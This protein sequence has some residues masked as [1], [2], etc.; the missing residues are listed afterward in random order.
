MIKDLDNNKTYDEMILMKNKYINSKNIKTWN[1]GSNTWVRKKHKN[2]IIEPHELLGSLYEN[3]C[4]DFAPYKIINK[5][6]LKFKDVKLKNGDLI[7]TNNLNNKLDTEK[8]GLGACGH[9]TDQFIYDNKYILAKG[10]NKEDKGGHIYL[11]ECENM[12]K[13]FCV[14]SVIFTGSLNID[15]NISK[16]VLNV[17]KYFGM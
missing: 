15:N 11:Y 17:Y 13:I 16:M 9:E 5:D 3:L 1:I 14:G 12:G 6:N 7:G 2:N 4:Y 8:F 10:I